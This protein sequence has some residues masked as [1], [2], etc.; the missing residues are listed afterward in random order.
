MIDFLSDQKYPLE[1]NWW[2][3]LKKVCRGSCGDLWFDRGIWWKIGVGNKFIFRRMCEHKRN[4][5]QEKFWDNI[6]YWNK[7]KKVIGEMGFWRDEKWCWNLLWRWQVFEWE[8]ELIFQLTSCLANV[9]VLEKRDPWIWEYSP[10]GLYTSN[11]AYTSQF[12]EVKEVNVIFEELWRQK[13]PSKVAFYF[14]RAWRDRLPSKDN[15]R[16][17]N[18]IIEEVDLRCPLCNQCR[19]T[20]YHLFIACHIANKVW[21][22]CY[23]WISL[24]FAMV[25]LGFLCSHFWLHSDFGRTKREGNIWKIIWCLLHRKKQN[26]CIFL[27]KILSIAP[28]WYK[29]LNFVHGLGFAPWHRD[30]PPLL[31]NEAT[32]FKLA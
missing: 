26:N 21:N 27:T 18:I 5:W 16:W 11:S 29:I 1:N 8:G 31:H 23:G 32:T 22:E 30:L 28:C 20:I 10:L 14:W 13:I 4:V 24:D 2:K 25:H 17:C 3:D 15:L 19:K 7:K 12:L 6:L 9:Q